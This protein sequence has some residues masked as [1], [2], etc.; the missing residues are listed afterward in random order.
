MF[1]VIESKMLAGAQTKPL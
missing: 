1:A